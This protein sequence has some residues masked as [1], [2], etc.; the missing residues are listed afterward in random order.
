MTSA[1]ELVSRHANRGAPVGSSFVR[2]ALALA[3]EKGNPF[4]AAEYAEARWPAYPEIAARLNKAAVPAI[5]AADAPPAP[6]AVEFLELVRA[7]EVVSRLGLRR[8]P[9]STGRV[10]Q[11]GGSTFVWLGERQSTPV[12]TLGFARASLDRTKVGGIVVITSDLARLSNPSAEGIVRDELVAGCVGFTDTAFLG[13]DPAVPGL[14]PAGMLHGVTPTA[15]AD[16][17]VQ[18]LLVLLSGFKRLG[19]VAVVLS[20]LN[21]LA[22]ATAVPGGLGALSFDGGVRFV[23]SDAA[24]D[25]LVAIDTD[26]VLLAEGGLA[27]EASQNATIQMDSSPDTFESVDGDTVKVSLWQANLLGLKVVRSI[28]WMKAPDS[29]AAISGVEYAGSGS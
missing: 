29:V 3:I 2:Q 13:D 1:T 6:E 22:M 4:A 20:P 19:G 11:T 23:V 21:A 8:V 17:P 16:D 10:L 15:S 26:R 7:Q 9:F 14:S 12:G 28:S 24:G 25:N 18:D 5:E 27:V